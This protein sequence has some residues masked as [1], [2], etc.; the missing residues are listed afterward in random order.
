MYKCIHRV[1][2]K[3]GQKN[4]KYLPLASHYDQNKAKTQ[5]I[6]PNTAKTDMFK[7][8]I[9]MFIWWSLSFCFS[10]EKSPPPPKNEIRLLQ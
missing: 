1:G 10:K 5:N 3:V 9:E 4:K 8:Q 7:L 6:Q 2:A